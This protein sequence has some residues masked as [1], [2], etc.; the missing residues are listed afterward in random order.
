MGKLA[1][2]TNEIRRA[3]GLLYPPPPWRD[4]CVELRVPNTSVGTIAGYF[5]DTEKLLTWAARLSGGFNYRRG[6]VKVEAVYVSLNPLTPALLARSA[7]RCKFYAKHTAQDGDVLRRRWLGLDFDP[8]RPSGVSSTDEEHERAL[9]RA[10]QAREWL[11]A[12]GWPEP[13]LA[14]S[15]NGAHLLYRVD[16][17]NT[18]E[19]TDLVRRVVEAVA[20]FHSGDGVDVDRKVYNAARLWKCYGTLAAK[21][22]DLPE[23][24][25][26]LARL[27]EIPTSLEV[28]PIE[29]LKQVAALVPVPAARGSVG[30]V[31]A[32]VGFDVGAWLAERGVEVASEKEWN[33]GRLWV[34]RRCPWRPKEH[35]NLSAFV[36]QDA[37]GR[38]VAKCHHNSCA[39]KGW[40]DLRD[41]IEP[42]WREKEKGKAPERRGLPRLPGPI[43]VP[44]SWDKQT[45]TVTTDWTKAREAY[46]AGKAVVVASR[47]L[48]VPSG[49]G[50]V[51]RQAA[52]IEVAEE[53][54]LGERLR[55]ALYPFLVL[56][57]RVPVVAGGPDGAG[58][59]DADSV[60]PG[61]VYGDGPEEEESE[62]KGVNPARIEGVSGES[63]N[64]EQ[65]GAGSGAVSSSPP[66]AGGQSGGQADAGEGVVAGTDPA[67]GSGADGVDYAGHM[68]FLWNAVECWLATFATD[69]RQKILSG[70]YR[71]WKDALDAV[72][73]EVV[74]AAADVAEKDRLLRSMSGPAACGAALELL[75]R[76]VGLTNDEALGIAAAALDLIWVDAL[77][78]AGIPHHQL[79]EE[80][81]RGLLASY[82]V[83]VYRDPA[84]ETGWS[85]ADYDF[86]RAAPPAGARALLRKLASLP[87]DAVL[88]AAMVPPAA[89]DT[90]EAPG[91]E[92]VIVE[93]KIPVQVAVQFPGSDTLAYIDPHP[94]VMA[95]VAP[96]RWRVRF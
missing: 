27:L 78:R 21:G 23:R 86:L 65:N 8:I 41:L 67:E 30:G 18:E 15:G 11:R 53:G 59:D 33:G 19:A 56:T 64:C 87:G 55:W 3:L 45:V 22:D 51:L 95:P 52:E 46:A 7:N 24:P 72:A 81:T 48:A 36:F 68:P 84:A 57:G 28:V 12:M 14:D 43:A 2:D 88:A 9:E 1:V 89:G 71:R 54:E 76:S 38:V 79:A 61:T 92:G 74:P 85:W 17:P 13:V 90:V 62:L 29:A 6:T 58:Q 50:Q 40:E 31:G 70:V 69:A 73:E 83:W 91:R 93:A 35:T 37:A 44:D 32:K 47:D 39:G 42:G 80:I 49:A 66:G 16:L 77:E 96:G 75:L 82:G 63:G 26:R 10:R 5:S 60:A 94:W 4:F 20:A 34:L 25:H